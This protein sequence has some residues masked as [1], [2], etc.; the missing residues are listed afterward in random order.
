[1]RGHRGACDLVVFETVDECGGLGGVA[2]SL[3]GATAHGAR[4]GTSGEGGCEQRPVAEQLG[5]LDRSLGPGAHR[6]VV[7]EVEAVADE[8]DHELDP[9]RGGRISELG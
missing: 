4:E 9:L 3:G 1:M 8:L 6:V 2:Q 7:A 5:G